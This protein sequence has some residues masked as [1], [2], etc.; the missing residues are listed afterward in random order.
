MN[1]VATSPS[2]VR[3]KLRVLIL[4]QYFPPEVGAPQARLSETARKLQQLGA[5]VEV[6]TAMPSYPTGRVFSDWRGRWFMRDEWQ[7]MQ[8]V[9]AFGY[10]TKSTKTL[11]RL[12]NYFSFVFSSLVAGLAMTKPC[13][14]ILVESP[15]LFLGLTGAC[16]RRFK[17]AAMVLNVSDLWPETAVALGLY[18]RESRAVRLAVGLERWLYRV[19]AAVTAQSSGIADGIRAKCPTANVALIPGGVDAQVFSPQRRDRA[20]LKPFVGEGRHV[21]GY[22]GLLGIAQG[23]EL[24]LDVAKRLE[25]RTDIVF[26]IAGDG[27]ERASLE[28]KAGANVVFAGLMPKADMPALVAS[29]DVTV[30]PLVKTIP[31]AL[32]SKMYEAMASEVPIVLAAEGDPRELLERANCGLYAPYSD[33]AAVASAVAQ[34]CD[35]RELAGRLGEAGRR[36]VLAHHVREVIAERLHGVLLEAARP[37]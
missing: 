23:I 21:V 24:L 3:A 18:S 1:S 16:L 11:P 30:I 17:R 13:D 31:G 19:S 37:T 28:R 20:V 9:R 7:G 26:L 15:P 34:L 8:V 29:F 10:P 25:H 12:L 33:A 6:L 32:P 22:A 14:V 2:S 35:D 27:P 5:E 4:T 36:Y